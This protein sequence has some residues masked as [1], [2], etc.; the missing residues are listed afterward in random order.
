MQ[1][2]CHFYQ[3]YYMGNKRNAKSKL[4][5]DPVPHLCVV[6]LIHL[7][8]QKISARCLNLCTAVMVTEKIAYVKV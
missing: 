3:T 1:L 2:F 5:R 4:T 6:H 8:H 7:L